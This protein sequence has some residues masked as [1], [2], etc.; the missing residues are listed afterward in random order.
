MNKCKTCGCELNKKTRKIYMGVKYLS[1]KKCISK[2]S[3]KYAK[4]RQKL[5]NQSNWAYSGAIKK[6]RVNEKEN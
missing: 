1:C 3:L 5:V 2:K 6:R 4:K